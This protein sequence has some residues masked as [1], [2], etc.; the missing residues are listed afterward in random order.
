MSKHNSRRLAVTSSLLAA[1]FVSLVAAAAA[2][3]AAP[4]STSPPTLE[5]RFRQGETLR[6]SNGL[7][8]NNPTSFV[9]RWQRCDTSGNNCR[10]IA[11]ATNNAYRLVQ[12]DVGQT[13]RSVVT[14]RNADG[15]SAANSRQSP[16]IADN[17]APGNTSPPTI[18]G[19]AAVG[20]QLTAN[21]G[22]WSGAPDRFGYQWQQCD[23]NGSNCSSIAGATGKI[24]GVRSADLGRTLRVAVTAINPRGRTTAVSNATPTVRPAIGGG[25]GPAIPVS[26]VSLPD[27]LVASAATFSPSAIRNRTDLM[28]MRVRVNDTR[29]RLVQGA[30]VYATGV[31]FGRITAMP[32]TATNSSGVATLTFR[33][34]LRLAIR[35]GTAVQIFLR[36]RKPG[37]SVLA[38]VSSRRLI[39]VRIVPG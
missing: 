12:A 29:G 2:L 24:F 33:P 22:G 35:G 21:E 26:S 5:G 14:A 20:E 37:D 18:S 31:P 10:T 15:A 13:V 28:T 38:G 39:Q 8:A 3:A 7:W 25:T 34:T 27:R 16:V 30:L 32:E 19:T 6:T 36:V 1:V 11:G 23:A 9:Y 4:R 17:T